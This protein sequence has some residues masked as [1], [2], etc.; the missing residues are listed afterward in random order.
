VQF[1]GFVKVNNG[2]NLFKSMRT[3]AV[4][5]VILVF[6][7]VLQE[8]FQLIGLDSIATK[9]SYFLGIVLLTLCTWAYSRYSRNN[10]FCSFIFICLFEERICLLISTG[11]VDRRFFLSDDFEPC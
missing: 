9:C 3:P 10:T 11:I 4:L 1:E 6:A 5:I 8:I 2:K 7:Y